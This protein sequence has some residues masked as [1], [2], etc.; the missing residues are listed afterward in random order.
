V[1][2]RLPIPAK[3]LKRIELVTNKRARF[4]LDAI[5]KNGIV[6]TID[7]KNAGYDHPP[8][9]VMDA[10]DLGFAIKKVKAKREDG[11]TIAAYEFDEGEL[12]PQ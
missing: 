10:K 2:N 8:R 7:L 5:V 4:V 3:L 11:R 9:A 1:P 6:S 12:D